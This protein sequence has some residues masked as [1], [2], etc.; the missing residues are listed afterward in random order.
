MTLPIYKSSEA[1]Y[2]V[3]IRNDNACSKLKK[4]LS[5]SK[6]IQAR[7]E[8]NRLNIYDQNTLCLF[9][10][11]WQHGFDDVMIW[12]QYLKRHIYF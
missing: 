2:T 12:D 4:W 11:G 9:V 5:S 10:T 8:D 1:L 6:T 7:V 3:I